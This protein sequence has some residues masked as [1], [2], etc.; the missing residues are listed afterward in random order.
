MGRSN[1]TLFREVVASSALFV[2]ATYLLYWPVFNHPGSEVFRP[3]AERIHV[4]VE[5]ILWI[6]STVSRNLLTQP[7]DL[8]AGQTLHPDP[9]P[10]ARSE[11]LLSQQVTFAPLFLAT[12][13]PVLAQQ[14][15]LLLNIAMCGVGLFLLLRHWRVSIPAALLGGFIYATFPARY[16]NVHAP[17]TSAVQYLPLSLLFLDRSLTTGRARH[18]ALFGL[19]LALQLLTSFYLAYTTAFFIS[20]YT[21]GFL[22]TRGIPPARNVIVVAAGGLAAL[23]MLLLVALPYLHLATSGGYREHDANS[24]ILTSSLNW[25][26][27][28]YPPIALRTWKW[29]RWGLPNYLGIV[30]L[31]L[32]LVGMVVGAYRRRT[33]PIVGLLMAT[34]VLYLLAMGPP[35]APD[36]VFW[37]KPFQ[38]ASDRLPG[39]SAI[40]APGRFG[41]G[42]LVGVASIAGL[43]ADALCRALTRRGAGTAVIAAITLLLAGVTASEF[44]IFHFRFRAYALPVGANVPSV[45]RALRALEPGP[46]IEVPGGWLE[47]FVFD[48]AE[49]RYSYFSIYHQHDVLNGY[50]GYKPRTYDLIMGTARSLPEPRAI[51]LLRKLTGLRFII[52]HDRQLSSDEKEMWTAPPGLTLIGRYGRDRLF[53][54]PPGPATL[55]SKLLSKYA[56]STSVLGTPADPM[57]PQGMR[58]EVSGAEQ[59]QLDLAKGVKSLYPGPGGLRARVTVTNRSGRT[60]PALTLDPAAGVR[61]YW[62]WQR[63][64]ASAERILERTRPLA[65]DLAPGEASAA[66]LIGATPKPGT[67]NLTIGLRQGDRVFPNPLRIA[68]LIVRQRPTRRRE[69]TNSTDQD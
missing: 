66:T 5:L 39:F 46:V 67:Y 13:N 20:F 23:S 31:A 60:W 68:G 3:F 45:Y 50:T 40:R 64:V 29:P 62:Y 30:P 37:G 33:F 56:S 59:W 2:F 48:R 34:F 36:A 41:M 65:Y 6:L 44:G 7:F 12:G 54:L 19:F 22:L 53:S 21:V 32:A 11:H 43:G 57:P 58:M 35:T 55:M 52:V 27:Y 47:P 1:S 16:F 24:L 15:T 17:N 63:T 38:W 51:D 8:F 14:L 25:T 4:D 18:G 26:S 42:M 49:A 69:P 28:L 9:M 61:W 10:I